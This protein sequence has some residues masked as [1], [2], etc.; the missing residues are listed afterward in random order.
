MP[1]N[2]TTS[3]K[4]VWN[5]TKK[6]L[7]IASFTVLTVGTLYGVKRHRHVTYL[8]YFLEKKGLLDE[9]YSMSDAQVVSLINEMK[10]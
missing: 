9:Y 3:A 6:P 4:K 2:A 7:A 5:K 1:S 10:K 8:N